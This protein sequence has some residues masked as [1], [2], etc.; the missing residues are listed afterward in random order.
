MLDSNIDW[1]QDLFYLERWCR[2]NPDVTEIRVALWGS[3]PLEATGVPS[4]GM[5]P[6]NDPKPGWYALSVNYLYDR[7]GQYRYFLNFEPVARAGYSIYIYHLTQEDVEQVRYR[8]GK[9]L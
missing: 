2:K 6:A 1:G 3:Y 5:P 9:M 4:V 7:E 8:Q